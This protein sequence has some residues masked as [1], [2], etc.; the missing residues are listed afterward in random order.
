MARG[1][2]ELGAPSGWRRV[3]GRLRHHGGVDPSRS[4]PL[5]T[6]PR[7]AVRRCVAVVLGAGLLAL[8]A[9][10]TSSKSASG[11]TTVT[12]AAPATSTQ[13]TPP[14]VPI[15][16]PTST[17]GTSPDGSGC[18]PPE[19]TKLPDGIWFGVLKAVDPS[20][21]TISL[22]LACWFSGDAAQAATGSA[23]PVPND[24]YVRNE[25][26]KVYVL[27]TV[28]KVAVV[29]LAQSAG[30]GLSGGSGPAQTGV[31]AAQSLIGSESTGYVWVEITDG[32][33]TVVQ[34]QFT[35]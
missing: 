13:P 11:P 22:D 18:T 23:S 5:T 14:S 8:A 7:P 25:N 10:C 20:A 29:P 34:A 19:G 24:H 3:G 32:L 31:A 16:I 9:S 15:S 4:H 6:R 2:P 30:G 28:V 12:S 26:P 35:P 17:D 1:A 27:P 33:V 21:G